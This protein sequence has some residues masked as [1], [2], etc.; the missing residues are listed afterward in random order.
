MIHQNDI[1]ILH[2]G[3]RLFQQYITDMWCKVEKEMLDWI[4]RNQKQLRTELYQGLAD[5]MD[6]RHG[7]GPYERLG[8]KVILPST[9]TGSPRQMHELYQVDEVMLSNFS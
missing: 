2:Q 7:D 3:E 1:N 4:R 5:A 9:H 6:A 8:T